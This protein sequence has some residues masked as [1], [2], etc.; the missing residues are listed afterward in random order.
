[1][2]TLKT[3][4]QILDEMTRDER[5][6]LLYLES[7]AVDFQG[8]VDTGKMNE[9]DLVISERWAGESF[10]RFTRL[11]SKHIP[12]RRR[13]FANPS[14]CVELSPL[15]WEVVALERKRRAE[16]NQSEGVKESLAHFESQGKGEGVKYEM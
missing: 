7:R 10:I 15:A 5:A 1:M 3:T 8:V 12:G 16:R 4:E 13:E 9:D 11:L 14:H 6:Q 2:N